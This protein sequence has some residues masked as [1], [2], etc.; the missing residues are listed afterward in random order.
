[1]ETKRPDPSDRRLLQYLRRSPAVLPRPER[2][3]VRRGQRAPNTMPA[4]QVSKQRETWR[5]KWR[6]AKMEKD[7]WV[8]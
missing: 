8:R 7:G 2:A 1:M 6:E 3:E 4:G 5:E